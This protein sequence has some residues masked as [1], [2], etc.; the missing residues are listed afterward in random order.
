[1]KSISFKKLLEICNN[2]QRC[3][4]WSI[5]SMAKVSLCFRHYKQIIFLNDIIQWNTPE[6]MVPY[7]NEHTWCQIKGRGIPNPGR[8][9]SKNFTR[10]EHFIKSVLSMLKLELMFPLKVRFQTL[11]VS[12]MLQANFHTTVR[13]SVPEN[14]KNYEPENSILYWTSELN[15]S[16]IYDHQFLSAK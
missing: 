1:M 2:A 6:D 10:I 4:L 13:Q 11:E 16:K 9:V 3:Q 12:Q 5:V 8:L 14:N 15:S 7:N